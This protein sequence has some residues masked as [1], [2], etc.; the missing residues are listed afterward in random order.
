MNK[1]LA[2]GLLIGFILSFALNIYLINSTKSESEIS[3]LKQNYSEKLE[4]KDQQIHEL[5]NLINVKSEDGVKKDSENQK[6][7]REFLTAFYTF[8]K[9]DSTTR[10]ERLKELTSE[11]LYKELSQLPQE[12]AEIN[13][14]ETSVTI[15]NIYIYSDGNGEYLAKYSL[16]FNMIG[17]QKN[18]QDAIALIKMSNGKVAE[19]TQPAV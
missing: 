7:A 3:S 9:E 2:G 14:Q 6:V 12:D 11:D 17:N 19:F 16:N 13:Q 4:R 8:K 15:S 18:K 10:F 1:R 5:K